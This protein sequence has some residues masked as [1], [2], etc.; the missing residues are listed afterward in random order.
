MVNLF[1]TTTLKFSSLNHHSNYMSFQIPNTVDYNLSSEDLIPLKLD[2][3]TAQLQLD[4]LS[5]Y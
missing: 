3:I 5:D 4:D 2:A 1:H